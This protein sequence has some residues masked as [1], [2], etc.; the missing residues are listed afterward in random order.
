MTNELGEFI[1]KVRAEKDL[2]LRDLSNLT[3]LSHAYLHNLES[4][5]D[6]R[7]GKPLSPTLASLEKLA[8]GLDVP[9]EQIIFIGSSS[10]ETLIQRSGR[11][12]RIKDELTEEPEKP[13]QAYKLDYNNLD[14]VPILGKVGAGI[15]QYAEDNIE[16]WM[17]VDR[18]IK[19]IHGSELDQFYYL[20]VHGDS[21]EPLFNDQDLVLIKQGPVDDGQ[22]AVV[23]CEGENACVK[24]IQHLK[25]QG[26]LM[27]ISRNPAYPPVMKPIDECK[28]LGKVILRIGEPRW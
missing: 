7:T 14:L 13:P 28:V 15:P 1:K 5:I 9:L 25:E 4:G 27:L 26:L 6:P 17:A 11:L 18:S 23:L 3:G 20:R 8:T 22:I 16:G 24:K 12:N 21:M 19:K 10:L 2:T